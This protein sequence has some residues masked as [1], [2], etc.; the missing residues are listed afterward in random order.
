MEGKIVKIISNLYSVCVG[1]ETIECQARGRF[2][3]EK[4]TPL[5]GDQ[6]IIDYE[7]KYILEI[8]PRKNFL[9]RPMIANVDCA[10]IVVSVKMPDLSLQLLDK[11]IAIICIHHIQP[12]LCFSKMDLLNE[13]EKKEITQIKKY[14]QKI[15][16]DVL[17]N[18]E[19]KKIK[20]IL[21]DKIVVVTG[22]TGAGK[23]TLLNRLDSRLH[24]KTDEISMA[25]GRG[26]HTTRHVELFSF[27]NF[28]LADTP[29]FSSLDFRGCTLED[30]KNSF[31]EFPLYP[32]EYKD[33]MHY[34]ENHCEVKNA[35]AK[36]L[37]LKS[38]YENYLRFI[39]KE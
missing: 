32:C 39:T 9:E 3:K 5:V 33:C 13:Q 2:R 21:K 8:L 30:I 25:L 37:I 14:Y 11:M 4:I 12:I 19:T 35:V 31:V 26:K 34:K 6:C 16:Y 27:E 7:K 36:N 24:L 22:Q 38:R 10:L 15:G 18:T 20:T 1:K 28:Y 29:G 17:E 23:S